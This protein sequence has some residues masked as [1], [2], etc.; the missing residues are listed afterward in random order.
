MNEW[1]VFWLTAAGL[2]TGLGIMTA[3]VAGNC[4]FGCAMNRIHAAGVGDT[5]GLA[6]ITAALAVSAPSAGVCA[7]MFLPLVF[8]WITS[9]VSSHF[10]SLLEYSRGAGT[11]QGTERI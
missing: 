10:L 8:L 4:R 7:K 1:I 2:T 6:L 11:R 9:P 3:G 5:L